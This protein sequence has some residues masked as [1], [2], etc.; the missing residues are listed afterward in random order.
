MKYEVT[1]LN[2]AEAAAQA[3]NDA[4]I[5]DNMSFGEA[6]A[7]ARA[8]QGPGGA[9]TWHGQVYGTYYQHEWNAMTPAQ[10]HAFTQSVTMPQPINTPLEVTPVD[11][12]QDMAVA[13]DE[14]VVADTADNEIHI[15]GTTV[16][17]EGTDNAVN[18]VTLDVNGS[19]VV[20]VDIDNDNIYDFAVADFD[21]S[22]NVLDSVDDIVPIDQMDIHVPDA[23][24][25][26][27]ALDTDSFNP[28]ADLL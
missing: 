1:G 27:A 24:D 12:G 20:L 26:M 19:S 21:N 5:T 17:A 4:V 2:P 18:L 14:P 23:A 25:D 16:L 6:F 8:A 9:F 7:A 11:Y 10:Q 13:A 3:G 28:L 15:L 22:G